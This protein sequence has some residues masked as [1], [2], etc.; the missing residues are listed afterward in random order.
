MQGLFN[1]ISQF[2]QR[3]AQQI[4]TLSP[5][6]GLAIVVIAGI[7]YAI[8]DQEMS[9][10]AKRHLK[11]AIIGLALVWLASTVINTLI[12][13]FGAQINPLSM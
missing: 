6:V 8:G 3:L 9:E 11:R 1:N 12:S 10:G 13:L 5:W 7:M 2:L 4:Q